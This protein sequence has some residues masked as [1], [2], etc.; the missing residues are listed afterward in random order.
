M[1]QLPPILCCLLSLTTNTVSISAMRLL[2]ATELRFK[3]FLESDLPAYAILS[4]R[5]GADEVSYQEMQEVLNPN[6]RLHALLAT[7]PPDIQD[8]RY[9]K[10]QACRTKALERNLQWIW[11][12]ACWSNKESCAELSEANNSMYKRYQYSRCCFVHVSDVDQKASKRIQDAEVIKELDRKSFRD[13]EWFAR[14][15]TLQELLAPQRLL[16]YDIH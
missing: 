9:A 8:E 3:E 13:S 7:T 16:F 2:H 5:W 11:V 15:W 4:R 12:N 10:I 1:R 6:R 14:G